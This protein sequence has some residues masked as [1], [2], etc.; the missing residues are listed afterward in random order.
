MSNPHGV[1]SNVDDAAWKTYDYVVVGGGLTG[2]AVA[3]RLAE[4]PA[5][6]VLVIE[7]G[8]DSRN[9]PRVYDVYKYGQ[10]FGT[11]L[12]WQFTADNGRNMIAYVSFI[13]ENYIILIYVVEKRWEVGPPSMEPHGLAVWPLSTMH[14]VPCWRVVRPP[15]TGTGTVSLPT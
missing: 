8:G 5:I 9:D 7:S 1:T 4:N 12:D 6:T 10:A 11:E 3:A 2:I 13:Y 14:G 15:S